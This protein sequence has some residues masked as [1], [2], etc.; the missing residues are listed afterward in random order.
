MLQSQYLSGA[1]ADFRIL[2]LC[3]KQKINP[4][5]VTRLTFF[6]FMTLIFRSLVWFYGWVI[7]PTQG[8]CLHR[9]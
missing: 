3:A 5:N 6:R 2:D 7:G 8:F 1:L 4:H 9:I